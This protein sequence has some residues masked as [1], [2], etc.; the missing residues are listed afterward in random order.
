MKKKINDLIE[1]LDKDKKEKINIY[2]GY[3][4]N[5]AEYNLFFEQEFTKDLKNTKFDY[6]LISLGILEREDQNEYKLK[7]DKCPNIEKKFYI[8]VLK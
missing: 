2:W 4:S 1:Y 3:L 6:S 7:R 8:M 5:Y